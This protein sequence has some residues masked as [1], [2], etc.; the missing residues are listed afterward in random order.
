MFVRYAFPRKRSKIKSNIV[1]QFSC[2]L[3]ISFRRVDV[4]DLRIYGTVLSLYVILVTCRSYQGMK[5]FSRAITQ[6]YSSTVSILNDR[7]LLQ[8][9]FFYHREHS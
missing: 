1:D 2:Y 3:T 5:W 7:R 6:F 8:A 9:Q 4:R